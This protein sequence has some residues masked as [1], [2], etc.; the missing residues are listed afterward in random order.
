MYKTWFYF[1]VAILCILGVL[2]SSCA[3]KTNVGIGSH[4]DARD[5]AINYLHEQYPQ[6]APSNEISWYE[7]PN[8]PRLS[9][10][11]A[12]REFISDG[13]AIEVTS[14][15]V[16]IESRVY[17]VTVYSFELGWYW[18]GN[19]KVDGTVSE[20]IKFKQLK[21]IEVLCDDFNKLPHINNEVELTIEGRLVVILCS[22]PSTGFKWEYF[23]SEENIIRE[24][25][26]EFEKSE[27]DIAGESGKGLWTF[28]AIGK[29]TTEVQMEYSQPWEDGEKSAWTF[30]L[31][32]N[33]K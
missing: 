3:G 9:A 22:N 2:L 23:T 7:K 25:D 18:K 29:G 14:G 6:N 24:D 31:T 16:S 19:I 21:V 13:W 12:I 15:L 10:G 26:Y 20:L 32:V 8:W 27:E 17:E 11:G 28:E 1:G 33:V 4:E 5:A 30:N